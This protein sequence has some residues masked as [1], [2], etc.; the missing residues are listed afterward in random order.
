MSSNNRN[1]QLHAAAVNLARRYTV[2]NENDLMQVRQESEEAI[3][4]AFEVALEVHFLGNGFLTLSIDPCFIVSN[5]ISLHTYCRRICLII[6]WIRCLG[7]PRST[8]TIPAKNFP[9]T[10]RISVA[11]RPLVWPLRMLL[12]D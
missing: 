6:P 4:M 5:L 7:H 2:Q 10:S 9:S 12:L 3:M 8:T 11:F 1:I